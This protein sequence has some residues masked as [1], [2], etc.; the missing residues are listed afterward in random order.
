MY[1]VESP[2]ALHGP[3]CNAERCTLDNTNTAACV[4]TTNDSEPAAQHALA[5]EMSCWGGMAEAGKLTRL[6]ACCTGQTAL[7]ERARVCRRAEPADTASARERG[8]ENETARFPRQTEDWHAAA[9]R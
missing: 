4:R 1:A 2:S 6:V 8:G 9:C 3:P 5:K 7:D